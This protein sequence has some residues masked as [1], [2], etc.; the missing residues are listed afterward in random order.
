[1]LMQVKPEEFHP[2]PKVDSVVIRLTFQPIPERVRKIGPINYSLLKKVVRG[3]FGQRR[4]T[5]LN[6]LSATGLLDKRELAECITAVGLAPSI[7]AE[8]LELENFVELSQVI[9]KHRERPAR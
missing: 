4:K 5:L 1:M 3:A 7:R 9:T 2:R 8:R 6:A